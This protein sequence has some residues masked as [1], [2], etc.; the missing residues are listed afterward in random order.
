MPN[1]DRNQEWRERQSL[2]P[3]HPVETLGGVLAGSHAPRVSRRTSLHLSAVPCREGTGA[4]QL[5]C[6]PVPGT[7]E[8]IDTIVV[9]SRTARSSR[10]GNVVRTCLASQVDS[11]DVDEPA[12]LIDRVGHPFNYTPHQFLSLRRTRSRPASDPRRGRWRNRS[13]TRRRPCRARRACARTGCRCC[14]AGRRR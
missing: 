11:Q 2:P 5:T 1:G 14:R 12:L 8:V 3:L 10:S 4:S 6:R 7:S 13:D 9:S